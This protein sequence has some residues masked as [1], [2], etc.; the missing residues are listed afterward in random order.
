MRFTMIFLLRIFCALSLYPTFCLATGS[1]FRLYPDSVSMTSAVLR[2]WV[3]PQ[4]ETGE[5]RFLWHAAGGAPTEWSAGTFSGSSRVEIR[6]HV[7]GLLP[8][9]LYGFEALWSPAP[10][11]GEQVLF[12]TLPD[13]GCVSTI[14]KLI[15]FDG[16]YG[17]ELNFGVRCDATYCADGYLGEQLVPPIPPQGGL[18]MRLVDPR[19]YNGQC[20]DQGMYIDFRQYADPAQTDTY[21]VRI[22]PGSLGYP[23]PVSWS[24]LSSYYSGPVR[25]RSPLN[26]SFVDVD[27]KSTNRISIDDRVTYLF[28]LA[29]GP[30]N[31]SVP[32]SVGGTVPLPHSYAVFQNYPN[33][34]NPSTT[35][36]Y[37][38][39]HSSRVSLTVYNTL[40]QQVAHLVNEQQQ[41]GYHDAV[42]NGN[43]VASG[44][45]YYRLQADDFVQTRKLLLLK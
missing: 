6:R 43:G 42:F 30:L 18:D 41:A 5:V 21:K 37:A 19:G 23:V 20:M 22:D 1:V 9:T 35:I 12:R 38:L 27:M 4:G 10:H 24:D 44:V 32:M 16:T 15:I 31:P 26:G 36:R 2:A 7:T 14:N 34:F 45:Y 25:M 3:N 8:N 40:G 33:P 28:V 39:P 13:T 11:Y 17:L 29:S